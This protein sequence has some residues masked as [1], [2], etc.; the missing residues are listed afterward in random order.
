MNIQ[1]CLIVGEK[2]GGVEVVSGRYA[3]G[4]KKSID[5]WSADESVKPFV[6]INP[7]TKYFTALVN[8]SVC[9][10][11][12]AYEYLLDLAYEDKARGA[13]GIVY[14]WNQFD[15]ENSLICGAL[16]YAHSLEFLT[17]E[18]KEAA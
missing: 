14:Y 8:D 7:L 10:D 5:V 17:Q 15:I 6:L 1:D 4:R 9:F 16:L 13:Q 11:D 18:T 12:D 2:D 3:Q